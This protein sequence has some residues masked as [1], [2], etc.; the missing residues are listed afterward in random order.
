MYLIFD[1][2]TT[3][4]PGNYQAPLTDSEN[5]PRMV[6]IA[7]QLHQ[8]DGTFVEA[9]N[10]IIKPD[11]FEI[12]YATV[13]IHGITTE[14]ALADGY[15]LTDVLERFN[16]AV[17]KAS[18]VIGHNVDF[19][20]SIVGAELHR[21]HSPLT[22]LSKPK[23]DTMK[24]TVDFCALPGGKGGKLKYPK[25]NELHFKLF[26]EDFD[27]AHNAAADVEATARCFLEL[28]RIGIFGINDLKISEQDYKDFFRIN[29]QTIQAV[30]LTIASNKE[31]EADLPDSEEQSEMISLA[32]SSNTDFV[33]LHLHTQYSIL[34]G[35]TKIKDLA[36]KAKAEGMTSIAITDHGTMFGV[37]EFHKILTSEGLK[38]IIGMEA[39]MAYRTMDKR[40]R[41]DQKRY[42]LIL[43]AKNYTGYQNLMK[44]ATIGYEEGFYYKPRIDKEVLRKYSEGL[45]ALSA[46]LG[47]EIPSKI[48][49]MGVEEGEK[50][51]MEYLDIFGEDFYLE[52]QRHPASDPEMNQNVYRDQLFVNAELLRL[53]KK[54]QVTVVATNDVHFLNSEDYLAHDR[55]V[56]LNTGKDL[57]DP[58]RMKYT[59]QEWFKTK[60]EMRELFADMPEVLANTMLVNNKI[61]AYELNHKPIMPD[62]NIPEGFENEDD[63]LRHITIEGAKMRWAEISPAIEERLDFELSVIKNM[64]FPGYFLIVWDFLK[65]AREMGVIVGP[66][67]GSAAGSA[68]AYCLRIT[69]I[70]PLKYNLLFE[71]FLNP[72]RVSMPDIDIDFDDD[73]REKILNWVKEKYGSRR[74][75][76]IATF[77]SMAA[78]SSI[79]DVA[80][81][82]KMSLSDADRLAKLVP[83]KPGVALQDAFKEVKELNDALQNGNEETKAVLD[84]ALKL[85]GSIR[86]T[87]THACGII[88][89]KDDLDKYIPLCTVKDASLEFATQYDG[90]HVESIGLLKMDFL[91]LKTLTIIKDA[92]HNI[93]LSKNKVID[94]ENLPL[95]DKETYELYSR[96]ETLGLFQFES[97]G[98]RM[99]LKN[100]K[101]SRLD[102]LIAMNALYRPGPMDYIESFIARKHGR[103]PIKYDLPEM[104]EYLAETYGITVYQEQVMLLSRKLAGFTAGQ[105][106]SLRKAMGK[107]IKVMM[108][109]L[110]ELFFSGC[111]ANGHPEAIVNK[112]WQDWEAFANYAFNKSHATCYTYVSYQTAY[113]KAHYPAEFMASVLSHNFKDINKLNFYLNE[114]NRM[115]IKV[116]GPHINESYSGFTVNRNGEIR[117]GLSGIKGVGEAALINIID[118]RNAK[119]PF[120]DVFDFVQRVN[121]RTVNKKTLESL[122]MVGC[123]DEL[124]EEN[125]SQYFFMDEENGTTFLEKI[126]KFGSR[127]Q[128]SQNSSQI[129]LFG[130]TEEMVIENPAFP[131]CEP[132]SKYKQLKIEKDLMGF[133]ISGHPLD[134]FQDAIKYFSKNTIQDVLAFMSSKQKR[135]VAFSGIVTKSQ[136]R[137]TRQ[138][139]HYAIVTVEDTDATIDF[140]LFTENFLK[141]KHVIQEE[142]FLFIEGAIV[143]SKRSQGEV[144]LRVE[145]IVLLAEVVDKYTKEIKVR[146]NL[147]DLTEQLG[148]EFVE[149]VKNNK[150]NSRLKVFF[151]DGSDMVQFKSPMHNVKPDSFIEA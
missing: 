133:Y 9:H 29:T 99:H 88:I 17:E 95:D 84:Y 115:K 3:G 146:L 104:E 135:V 39:Y 50:A 130:D 127:Y 125:R 140:F 128:E 38:P 151:D 51:L 117:Y 134:E 10:F 32:D 114:C 47:G 89:G 105:S 85:E 75:A 137:E 81:V 76:H 109:E 60:A 36:K 8:A 147:E 41:Q 148:K 79:R 96:G 64:G 15:P 48:M 119:G 1:T 82:Q 83:E 107:K 56:C 93:K 73:G 5:W 20:I 121:L 66:G 53:A 126:L 52:I 91:G 46:C 34:D 7:W 6:Q 37:K 69:D 108:D 116:L 33:H 141:F 42:H 145:N 78:K 142:T 14:K 144:E 103:E 72:D 70:D 132:W 118:E 27:E 19:D 111:K 12:P 102:D 92:I 16:D 31:K 124:G 97:E 129:S 139:T 61:E 86:S 149:S 110:K 23:L 21:T 100:L 136:I 45:I 131:Q 68:V 44:L 24:S 43:L 25:L 11:G 18:I 63:Y 57:D 143:D 59:G 2:E 106:D 67:R 87:G 65:A 35:L 150:G 77:G 113:L 90:S 120:K 40:D 62:F 55:L 138:N 58:N 94:I 28:I 74:V 80:R 13:K 22:L 26:T 54:H 123:F 98:M 49:E 122:V 4:T 71:R 101:P 30:G 112:I